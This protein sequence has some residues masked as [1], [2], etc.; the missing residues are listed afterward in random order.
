MAKKNSKKGPPATS[1]ALPPPTPTVEK[2]LMQLHDG[3]WKEFAPWQLGSVR[4]LA[5]EFH[6]GWE[7]VDGVEDLT[8]SR[9]KDKYKRWVKMSWIPPD[10]FDP[11]G[12][13]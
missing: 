4:T 8:Q 9:W 5:P 13:G 11:P 6:Q 7:I 3:T 2:V 1:A 10:G 12:R